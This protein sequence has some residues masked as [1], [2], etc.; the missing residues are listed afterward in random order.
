MRLN[1]KAAPALAVLALVML[2]SGAA[3]SQTTADQVV[4]NE[5]LKAFVEGAKAEIEAITDI[6]EG[7]KLR[8]RLRTEGPGSP[9]RC[10]SSSFSRAG[11]RSSTGTIA[12]RRARICSAS[13][14]NA[15][16]RSSRNSSRPLPEAEVSSNTTTGAE[17]GIR[18]RI[19]LRDHRKT[20]RAGRRLLAGR[21][22]CPNPDRRPAE[23]R[24]HRI[25]GRGPRDTHHLR[26]GSGQG[27]PRSRPVRRL[28]RPHRDQKRLPGGRRGLEIRLHLFVGRQWRGRHPVSRNRAV[29][30]RQAHGHDEDGRLWGEVR[31]GADRRCA[32]RGSEVLASITTTTQPSRET[33]TPVPRSSVTR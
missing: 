14:T 12:R 1:L 18:G 10:S 4:D 24:R 31:R 23:A 22:P 29:S 17:D 27:V 7:A 15:E 21:L 6:N 20:I 32:A 26:R 28:Q 25:A 8:D 30:R 11:N 33:R 3:R 5:T 2:A 9:D 13:R 16:P 19:H